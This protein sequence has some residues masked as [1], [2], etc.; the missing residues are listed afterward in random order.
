MAEITQTILDIAEKVDKGSIPFAAISEDLIRELVMTGYG[1]EEETAGP[2][3]TWRKLYQN[4]VLRND[5]HGCSNVLRGIAENIE[6]LMEREAYWEN[7]TG[8]LNL[9]LGKIRESF[10]GDFYDT[11]EIFVNQ[12]LS[13]VKNEFNRYD[14]VVRYLAVENYYQKNKNG[15]LLYEKMQKARKGVENVQAYT[16]NLKNLIASFEE[17]GYDGESEIECDEELWL[18]DGSH[19]MAMY[20]YH[21]IL[22]IRVKIRS[23]PKEN[24]PYYGI[25]WFRDNGFTQEELRQIEQKQEEIFLKCQVPLQVIL[26]PPVQK[27]FEEI[28]EVLS[29]S[30]PV[31]SWSDRV[32]SEETFPRIVKGIYH[33]DDIEAWKIQKKLEH[34]TGEKKIRILTLA[35]TGPDYRL[36]SRNKKPISRVGERI[37][38]SIRN[39]YKD[40]IDHYFYDIIIHTGDNFEQNRYLQKL[41]APAFDLTAYLDKISGFPYF[42]IKTETPYQTEDFPKTYPFSKD[43]DIVVSKTEFEKLAAFTKEYLKEAAAGYEIR[44]LEENN[45]CRIRVELSGFLIYQLDICCSFEGLSDEFL[46]DSLEARCR[47]G[48]YFIPKISDEIRFRMYELSKYPEKKHHEAYIRKYKDQLQ[49]EKV[50]LC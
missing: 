15:F 27:Y 36:K 24:R 14:I 44:V 47:K 11:K 46:R 37:K 10:L 22:K 25:D 48:C 19:R 34:M 18:L 5:A 29:N 21:D 20:L 8:E 33:I 45:H 40:K 23:V 39:A 17:K 3:Q 30:F 50:T 2:V 38:N 13:P 32:Y 28:T 6:Y 41:F 31:T 9:E 42:L 4:F 49:D 35:L 26:W 16:D 43:L 12:C 1:I 7:L